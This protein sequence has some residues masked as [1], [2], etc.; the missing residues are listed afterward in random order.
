M[1]FTC[2]GGSSRVLRSALKAGSVDLVAVAL[3]QVLG[4]LADLPDVL[5]AV[6]GGAVDLRDVDRGAGGDLGARLADAA[7]GGGRAVDAVQRLG[8]QASGGGLPHAAGAAEEVGVGDPV[9]LD[10]VGHGPDHVLLAGHVVEGLGAPL[11]RQHEVA[12]TERANV[13]A[14]LP[15]STLA[16]RA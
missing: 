9:Q 4:V 7:R 10:G 8:K 6:V 12:H 5:D 2:P 14:R 13:T 11:P 15:A 3:G 1:N 16:S